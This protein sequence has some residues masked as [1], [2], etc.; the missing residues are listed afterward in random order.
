MG[1]LVN[2]TIGSHSLTRA[3]MFHKQ[4]IFKIRNKVIKDTCLVPADIAA[5]KPRIPVPGNP[6]TAPDSGARLYARDTYK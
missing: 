6:R 5:Q 2:P 4:I 1:I 3:C